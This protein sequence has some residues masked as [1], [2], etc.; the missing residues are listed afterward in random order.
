MD[1]RFPAF[2]SEE[3]GKIVNKGQDIVLGKRLDVFAQ[4]YID[5]EYRQ[6]VDDGNT[7]T[8]PSL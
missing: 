2:F 1:D 8:D 4:K 3:L 6:I 5:M 7:T